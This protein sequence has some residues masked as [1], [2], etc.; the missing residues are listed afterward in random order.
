M[1][2]DK[3]RLR[4]DRCLMETE[5]LREMAGWTT[6]SHSHVSGRDE[7]DLCPKCWGN[8]REFLEDRS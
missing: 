8:F 3:P 4:C 6:L 2:V 5:N 7:W 1:R